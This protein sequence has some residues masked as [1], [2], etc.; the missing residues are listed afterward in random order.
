MTSKKRTRYT[1]STA[2]DWNSLPDEAILQMRIRDLRLR[3]DASD[4]RPHIDRLY[5]EL[6]VKGLVFRPHCYLADEWFCP[7]RVPVIG[8]P[9][10]LAH[11]R[12]KRLEQ[13]MMDEIEGGTA[14]TCMELLRHECGHAINYAY[15]LYKKRKWSEFFGSF[16]EEYPE[17]YIPRPYSRQY[18]R[19]LENCYAQYHPDE[20][21]A[22]TFAV[23][24]TPGKN[25]EEE[26]KGWRGA[27]AKLKYVDQLMKGIVL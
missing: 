14:K 5:E 1:N 16:K 6:A 21:F 22:E 25:W 8:L 27:L 7:D 13:R 12:L 10:C 20:D 4:L 11:P 23:W 17:T 9:F 3:I 15:R 2:V 26:Y 18:V 24:L 19:H